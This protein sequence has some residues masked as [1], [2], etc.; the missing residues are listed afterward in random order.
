MFPTPKQAQLRNAP[1]LL[2]LLCRFL[3]RRLARAGRQG[4]HLEASG[5]QSR[6]R[7][8]GAHI[9]P[10]SLWLTMVYGTQITIVFMGPH[11]VVSK[12]ITG[13]WL[14]ILKNVEVNGKNY[15]IYFDSYAN[16]WCYWDFLGVW[17]HHDWGWD[18]QGGIQGCMKTSWLS[19]DSLYLQC[20]APSRGRVQLGPT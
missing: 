7:S 17:K 12:W 1:Q 14:T 18:D 13:W 16:G 20:G 8:V 2:Q 15:P 10:V 5:P 9:T 19:I 4:R 3:C 6:S 11:I